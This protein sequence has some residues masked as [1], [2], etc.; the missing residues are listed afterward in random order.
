MAH[1]LVRLSSHLSSARPQGIL[2][3]SNVALALE[4][5]NQGPSASISPSPSASRRDGHLADRSLIILGRKLIWPAAFV[6]ACLLLDLAEPVL[7]PLLLSG[8]N[9]KPACSAFVKGT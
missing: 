6:G 9:S 2:S 4:P 1:L 3:T 7:P 5:I 8:V